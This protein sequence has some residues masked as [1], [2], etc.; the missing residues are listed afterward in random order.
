MEF[1]FS[2]KCPLK[3][4]AENCNRRIINNVKEPW[5]RYL[6]RY[7]CANEGCRLILQIDLL[8]QPLDFVNHTAGKDRRLAYRS[9]SLIHRDDAE[10]MSIYLSAC[11]VREW[12]M[13]LH[14]EEDNKCASYDWQSML[15]GE[16]FWV[17]NSFS[18]RA[19]HD[20][21]KKF[22]ETRTIKALLRRSYA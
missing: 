12:K 7:Y 16:F 1:N 22:A 3:K 20:T 19:L 5:R 17:A 11:V 13:V 21:G 10:T 8:P 18:E 4:T 2:P 6:L 14:E 9:N 15:H